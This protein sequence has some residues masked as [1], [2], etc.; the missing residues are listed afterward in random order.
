MSG[1]ISKW[2]LA[3]A[4]LNFESRVIGYL[5]VAMLILSALM[6]AGY[7]L[8]IVVRGF[9]PGKD[10]L[11]ER[12]EVGPQMTA[13]MMLLGAAVLLFG[14]FPNGLQVWISTLLPQIF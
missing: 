10:V 7:L 8:P 3:S 14:L 4:A 13:P 1:F 11:V 5:G 2:Y 6:T 9:F 12:R